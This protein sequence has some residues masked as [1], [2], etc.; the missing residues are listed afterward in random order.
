MIKFVLSNLWVEL[1]DQMQHKKTFANK[2]PNI[3]CLLVEAINILKRPRIPRNIMGFNNH[4]LSHKTLTHRALIGGIS[5][6]VRGPFFDSMVFWQCCFTVVFVSASPENTKAWL[7]VIIWLTA[8][9]EEKTQ[10]YFLTS[11]AS[12]WWKNVLFI[13]GNIFFVL[14]A[15]RHGPALRLIVMKNKCLAIT[16]NQ[17]KCP[18]I[19]P[20][21]D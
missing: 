14:K 9:C 17:K 4:H 15:S 2:L 5:F 20:C 19:F 7:G 3:F 6:E 1:Q 8:L 13:N 21:V 18:L 11:K 16:P 12:L 10:T